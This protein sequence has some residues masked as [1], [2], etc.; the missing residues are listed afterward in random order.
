MRHAELVLVLQT[1]GVV[2]LSALESAAK[3]TVTSSGGND[4]CDFLRAFDTVH[5]PGLNQSAIS[6]SETCRTAAPVSV[7]AALSDCAL[8]DLRFKMP[9][10]HTKPAIGIRHGLVVLQ[11]DFDHLIRILCA[12][13]RMWPASGMR[14]NI[15][16]GIP[17]DTGAYPSIM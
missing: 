4:S 2:S 14:T 15:F 3:L 7:Y 11:P 1:S 12:G 16:T 8:P 13:C 17:S 6:R 5:C 10:A 9:D